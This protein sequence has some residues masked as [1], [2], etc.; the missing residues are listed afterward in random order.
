MSERTAPKLT[1]CIQQPRLWLTPVILGAAL[2]AAPADTR[3]DTIY[4][5]NAGGGPSP[6]L[7]QYGE[8]YS[9]GVGTR[10][11]SDGLN[12]PTGLAFDGL[13]NLFVANSLGNTVEKITPAG[14]GS[15][16]CSSSL[17]NG[18]NLASSAP[19]RNL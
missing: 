2:L 13:G 11:S 4:V 12:W 10:F 3:A 15:V 6:Q 18:P 7:E 16:F 5:S 9:S 1:N 17:L 19:A 8:K 14:V